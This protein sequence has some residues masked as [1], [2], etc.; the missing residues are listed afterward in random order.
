MA[1]TTPTIPR[2]IERAEV[3]RLQRA[4]NIR[5]RNASDELMAAIDELV[6]LSG[7]HWEA[8]IDELVNTAFDVTA[9][10]LPVPA[11][12][13]RAGISGEQLADMRVRLNG[14]G[15]EWA[16]AV[17]Q[18]TGAAAFRERLDGA[19]DRIGHQGSPTFRNRLA[20][21]F[22]KESKTERRADRRR[23]TCEAS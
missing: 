4:S 18:A 16:R 19:L 3:H 10:P 1:V 13:L 21:A 20:R 5:L 2:T 23:R 8:A 11:W 22:D 15:K 9:E 7:G 17:V 6:R 12:A 14:A